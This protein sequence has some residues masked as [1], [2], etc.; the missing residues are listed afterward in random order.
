MKKIITLHA[1][2]LATVKIFIYTASCMQGFSD[3][4][5]KVAT[6]LTV[7]ELFV[8]KPTMINHASQYIEASSA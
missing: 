3:R 1:T 4:G 5:Y 7:I 6:C 8:V 2:R